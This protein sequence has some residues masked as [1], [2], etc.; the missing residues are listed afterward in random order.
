MMKMKSFLLV[1]V[2]TMPL[3]GTGEAHALG[4]GRMFKDSGLSPKD[5]SVMEAA[6]SRLLDP[7]G[8]TGESRRWA[9]PNSNAK[10]VVMLGM[11]EGNCAE[12]VYSFSTVTRPRPA[13][14]RFWRCQTSE[15]QWQLSNRP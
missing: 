2:L 6:A 12:L 10:G 4:L 11:I 9:N 3:L 14:Y 7:L 13:T 15:G 8:K 1:V 5:F